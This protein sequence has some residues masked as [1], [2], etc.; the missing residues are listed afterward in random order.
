MSGKSH[1]YLEDVNHVPA[2]LFDYIAIKSLLMS[3]LHWN[4]LILK[5][6]RPNETRVLFIKPFLCN[7]L[8]ICTSLA[9]NNKKCWQC[10]SSVISDYPKYSTVYTSK[11]RH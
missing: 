5:A 10:L 4:H 11:S 9:N 1:G 6:F 2:G 7:E 3:C 8:S